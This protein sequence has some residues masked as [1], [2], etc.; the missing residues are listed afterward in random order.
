MKPIYSLLLLLM[1]LF[2]HQ[3]IAQSVGIGTD[4]PHQSAALDISST[5]KGV[6]IPRLTTVQRNAIANPAKGLQILNVDD[7]CTDVFDGTAWIKNCGTR[8]TGTALP[9]AS[10]HATP[11]SWVRKLDISQGVWGMVQFSINNKGYVALGEQSSGFTAGCWE[12]DPVGNTWAQ[13]AN[14]PGTLRYY[15]S[16]W[17]IGSKG[18]VVAGATSSIFLKDCWEFDPSANSWVQKANL[19]GSARVS[20]FEFSIGYKGYIS[21]GRGPID[22]WEYDVLNDSWVQRAAPPLPVPHAWISRFGGFS[23]AVGDKGYIGSGFQTDFAAISSYP[24]D[25]WEYNPATNSWLQKAN[26]PGGYRFAPA[27]FVLRE[28][29]YVCAGYFN[30][31]QNSGELWR[32]DPATDTWTQRATLD[33]SI[34][35]AGIGFTLGKRGYVGLGINQ[36][37]QYLND[38]WEYQDEFDYGNAYNSAPVLT[39]LDSYNNGSWTVANNTIYSSNSGN[40]G[41]GTTTPAY[42]LEIAGT[43]KTTS[44]ETNGLFVAGTT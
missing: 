43:T 14:F 19:P 44:V 4:T 33:G 3:L 6:L 41:I 20:A 37:N 7:N 27:S 25:L 13:K 2:S 30:D 21:C 1:I 18:Y 38:L 31:T 15:A 36:W 8:V 17:S 42:K 11:N 29:G 26:F 23:F 9:S 16:S 22:L 10:N 35:A 40:I 34:R 5:N 32:Y 28:K 24:S 39:S 12:Y